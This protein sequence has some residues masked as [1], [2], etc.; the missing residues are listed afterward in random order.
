MLLSTR[1]R[2]LLRAA[3]ALSL[4]V[5]V[6]AGC[7]PSFFKKSADRET[8][9]ILRKKSGFVANADDSLLSITP[10]GPV[11]LDSLAQNNKSPEFLGKRAFIE[12]G[13]RVVSLSDALNYA[14]HRNRTYLTNK[15]NVYISA[16]GLTQTRQQYG[17]IFDGGGG[18]SL[19]ETQV[20]SGVNNFV[21][22]STL[23]SDGN[24]GVSTLTRFGT[25][26]ALDLTT[27]FT[28]FFTGGIRNFSDS[29]LGVTLSQPLLRGA[30]VLAASEP[31]R[32]GE[33]NVLYSIR[34]FTQYRKNF[35]V[36]IA[37]QYYQVLGLREA[38]RNRYTAYQTS[39]GTM[40]RERAL[41]EANI[42]TKSGLALIEQTSITYERNWI[43]AIRSYEDALD[44]FKIALG[45]PVDEAIVLKPE[46]LKRLQL[47]N[48]PGSVDQSMQMALA[49]RLD[50]YNER[51]NMQ[52]AVRK[53]KIAEQNLL[54]TV[55]LLTRYNINTPGDN[56]GLELNPGQR[57]S[58]VG[59][60]VDLNLNTKPERN[61]LRLAQITEQ[62][63]QRDLELAEENIRNEIRGDWRA[64]D[65]AA[66]QV[67]LARKG[68]AS[69]EYRLQIEE[70]LRDEGRG[71]ARDL[72]DAQTKLIDARDLMVNSLINHVVL[73]LELWRDM[74][75]LYIKK[76]GSWADVLKQERPKGDS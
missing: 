37:S 29:S 54:P 61:A 11:T 50:L 21:R 39:Q 36:A 33:R 76:D 19:S 59:L 48:I 40:E 63:A 58:S 13:A 1:L 4:C 18:G 14:V 15:E 31:L 72:V 68:L 42:R 53:V 22:T 20:Q 45:L 5:L 3:I 9:G 16:L 43:N 27:D 73:R 2:P 30:G 52:D 24:V 44:T 71:E 34:D 6:L 38:A 55:N 8:F 62:R 12:K 23:S 69:A 35:T 28:R 46:E 51:D 56:A 66:T 25:Q 47:M 74:G 26:I 57:N 17:L 67:E 49:T 10:P 32:Q 7:S 41:A 60:G 70:A 64:L 65:V 75:I